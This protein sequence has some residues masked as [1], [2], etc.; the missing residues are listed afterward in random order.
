MLDSGFWFIRPFFFLLFLLHALSL[1]ISFSAVLIFV[2]FHFH[3]VFLSHC[4]RFFLR[5]L[6]HRSTFTLTH[7]YTGSHSQWF[8]CRMI[9]T[10]NLRNMTYMLLL[11][12]SSNFESNNWQKIGE[13]SGACTHLFFFSFLFLSLSPSPSLV[14]PS[15][16]AN[17][18]KQDLYGVTHFTFRRLA[19]GSISLMWRQFTYSLLY[20]TTSIRLRRQNMSS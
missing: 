13:A 12:S 19:I 8:K 10:Y 5:L 20:F 16:Y 9:E 11:F 1:S 4:F 6:F 2:H 14:R 7:K 3:F 15:L 18:C 17:N